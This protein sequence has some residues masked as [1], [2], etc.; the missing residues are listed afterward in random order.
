MLAGTPLVAPPRLVDTAAILLISFCGRHVL[1]VRRVDARGEHL[2]C[3]GGITAVFRPLARRRLRRDGAILSWMA[4]FRQ[5]QLEMADANTRPKQV[6]ASIF[7]HMVVPILSLIVLL[8]WIFVVYTIP[9]WSLDR[10]SLQ[11]IAK[12]AVN[13]ARNSVAVTAGKS[14]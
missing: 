7:W 5:K 9:D 1:S 11:T 12:T 2:G 8:F 13:A 6:N 10:P 4:I 3:P 14:P